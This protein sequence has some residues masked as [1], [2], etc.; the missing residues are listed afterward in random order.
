MPFTITDSRNGLPGWIVGDLY[1]VPV[2]KSE[3]P[4][5]GGKPYFFA[6]KT[7]V[8]VLHSVEGSNM[9]ATLKQL[10]DK[11]SAPTFVTGDNEIVQTRPIWAQ[12]STL[13]SNPPHVPNSQAHIQ[14]EQLYSISHDSKGVPSLHLPPQ[15]VLVG[16]LAVMAFCAEHLGIPLQK[17]HPW[18]DDGLDLKGTIWAG[19]NKRRKSAAA[20][21]WP[22]PGWW[23]H[24]EVPWQQ[25]SWHHDCGALRRTELFRLAQELLDGEKKPDE[26]E[27]PDEQKKPVEGEI[28]YTVV[29]GDGFFRIAKAF[30]IKPSA[31]A[32]A[33]SLT[34]QSVLRPGQVLVIPKD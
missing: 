5:L 10:R 24:L 26:Q 32:K 1:G 27:K 31:L 20:G 9:K 18:P 30:G 21:L 11:G 15:K 3:C 13:R 28:T 14:I 6:S 34:L 7:G 23:M 8:G 16:T 19:N 2:R 17:P 29:Q 4:R 22:T 33:N 25:P 12:T